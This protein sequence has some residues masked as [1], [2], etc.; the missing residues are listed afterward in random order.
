MRK[1]HQS[2][3]RLSHFKSLKGKKKG[4]M[5]RKML[6][7]RS[8]TQQSYRNLV[9]YH[10]WKLELEEQKVELHIQDC[11]KH[12]L[13]PSNQFSHSYLYQ[14]SQIQPT[15]FVSMNINQV[16]KDDVKSMN[17]M[18]LGLEQIGCKYIPT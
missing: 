12:P 5:K 1:Q 11:I 15:N 9:H 2:D 10:T 8:L 14:I 7:R 17:A 18:L 13:V 6:Q 16:T 3:H 4:K